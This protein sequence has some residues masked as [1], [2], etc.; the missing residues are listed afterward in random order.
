MSNGPE[1]CS[2]ANAQI[3]IV[4]FGAGVRE[5]MRWMNPY[6]LSTQSLKFSGLSLSSMSPG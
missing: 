2:E 3:K 6:R 4:E 5:L 1:T